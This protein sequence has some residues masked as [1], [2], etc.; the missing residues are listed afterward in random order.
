[1][2]NTTTRAAVAFGVLVVLVV[3]PLAAA[4]GG[5]VASNGATTALQVAEQDANDSDTPDLEALRAGG[6]KPANAPPSIR[7]SGTYSEFALKYLPT[8]IWVDEENPSSWQ[9]LRPGTT[10][11]RDTVQVWSKR[12]YGVDSQDVTV[13]VAHYVERQRTR[14]NETVRV[15]ENVTTYSV[16][17]TVGGGYDRIPVEMRSHY[18]QAYRTVICV[19]QPGEPNCLTNPTGVRWQLNH[20]TS[21]AMQG[22]ALDSEGDK[23]AWGLG[24][25]LLPFLGSSLSF[26]FGA[27][28]AINAAKSAPRIPWWVGPV[29]LV[30]S[31]ISLFVFWDQIVATSVRAPWALSI[32]GGAVTGLVAAVWFGASRQRS[33]FFRL[34]PREYVDTAQAGDDTD[35]VAADGGEA[36]T[37]P[38]QAQSSLVADLI[39]I[40]MVHGRDGE[41]YHVAKGFFNW[42]A[43]VRGATAPLEAADDETGGSLQTRIDV[44]RGPYSELYFLDAKADEDE[45]LNY[46]PEGH[47]WSLPEV[48]SKDE[49]GWHVNVN[50]I[51]SGGFVFGLTALL[52]QVLLASAKLGLLIAGVILALW[53][54]A[55]PSQGKL[56][57]KLANIHYQRALPTVINHAR[58]IADASTKEE[59]FEN[60]TEAEMD[61]KVDRQELDDRRDQSQTK[62]L[63][64]RY[65]GEEDASKDSDEGV[66]SASTP[67][68]EASADD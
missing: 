1:V 59:L 6:E 12:G 7:A 3:A 11:K 2:T 9:Y 66:P 25:V 57:A 68:T 13:R 48:V 17:A 18:E 62:R 67:D 29:L 20:Q 27:R 47:D 15:A 5:A 28:K 30:G 14:D 58:D 4:S 52:G 39:P 44:D 32:V 41:R 23:I 8:G 21:E 49:D 38:G 64:D 45:V 26:I 35:A 24:F 46:E 54:F 60:W 53:K 63:I 43:R 51:A 37:K 33:M 10:V 40:S 31:V 55:T 19:E 50:L 16:D 56:E 22:I 34:R 42:I 65:L 36:P 61:R